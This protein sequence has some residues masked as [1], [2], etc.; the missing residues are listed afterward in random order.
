MN[1]A[2]LMPTAQAWQGLMGALNAGVHGAGGAMGQIVEE[3]GGSQG[4][5]NR[6]KNETI[7]FANFA[8]IEGGMG[9]FSRPQV[10]PQ[11]GVT[12]KVVGGLPAETDFVNAG[13]VLE[14]PHAEANLRRMWKEDGITPAEAVHDAER[15]AFLKHEITAKQVEVK[16]DPEAAEILTETGGK[17]GSLAPPR[18]SPATCRSTSS[19]R[20]RPAACSHPRNRRP[21]SCSTSAATS[22]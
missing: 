22:R 9:R 20:A 7:N 1:E 18:P 17:P 19:P 5:A 15:D 3:F 16:I 4:Q 12:E 10:D 14:S 21:K 8:M 6:A 13:K 2:V 11:L